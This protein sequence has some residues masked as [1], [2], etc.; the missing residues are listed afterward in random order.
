MTLSREVHRMQN[1][2]SLLELFLVLDY[3][4]RDKIEEP[5]A[6]REALAGEDGKVIERGEFFG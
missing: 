5:E 2:G 1:I 6:G 3:L 4:L